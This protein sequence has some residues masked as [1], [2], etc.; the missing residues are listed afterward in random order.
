M[1]IFIGLTKN[2][3]QN[4]KCI[5]YDGTS[6]IVHQYLLVL[7]G[8]EIFCSNEQ[9]EIGSETVFITMV[10]EAHSNGFHQTQIPH[11]PIV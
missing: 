9:I 6:E 11:N 5:Y 4:G 3:Y 1:V 2:I 7:T 10:S 8:T